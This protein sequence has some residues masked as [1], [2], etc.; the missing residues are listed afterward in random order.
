VSRQIAGQTVG[1]PDITGAAGDAFGDAHWIVKLIAIVA[2]IYIGLEITGRW[3]GHY[4]GKVDLLGQNALGEQINASQ[5][6]LS[7]RRAPDA[8]F[9]R[10]HS[11]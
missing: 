1:I 10:V 11:Q 6:T 7:Q 2:V 3:T 9:N 5:Q 8:G 4:L